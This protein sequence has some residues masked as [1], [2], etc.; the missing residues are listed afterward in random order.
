MKES[1]QL[2]P[3]DEEHNNLSAAVG[4]IRFLHLPIPTNTMF[5]VHLLSFLSVQVVSKTLH[6]AT[7]L[8]T[9][10]ELLILF[11]VISKADLN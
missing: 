5:S 9:V 1:F 11:I 7:T 8:H 4:D 3:Q 2:L 10:I 6:E